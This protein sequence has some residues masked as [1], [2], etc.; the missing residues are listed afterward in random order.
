MHQ[1]TQRVQR[2]LPRLLGHHRP[3]C[4]LDF[5]IPGQHR[6]AP[7]VSRFQFPLAPSQGCMGSGA[8]IQHHPQPGGIR[9]IQD[10]QVLVDDE[11]KCA[12]ELMPA[13]KDAHYPAFPQVHHAPDQAEHVALAIANGVGDENAEMAVR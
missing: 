13:D 4:A 3:V 9:V 12:G 7:V 11:R 1:V 5:G 6:Y 8:G 10:L 2:I